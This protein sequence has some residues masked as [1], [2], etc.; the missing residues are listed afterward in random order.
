MKNSRRKQETFGKAR[1]DRT[2]LTVR[3]EGINN[4]RFVFGTIISMF[5]GGVARY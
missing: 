2:L 1:L 5:I 3:K 4:F